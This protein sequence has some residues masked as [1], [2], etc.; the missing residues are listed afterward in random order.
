MEIALRTSTFRVVVLALGLAGLLVTG[1]IYSLFW[2]SIAAG[3]VFGAGGWLLDWRT[4]FRRLGG[5]L[6]SWALAAGGAVVGTKWYVDSGETA[7]PGLGPWPSGLQYASMVFLS[8]GILMF[9]LRD[10]S[11]KAK[12]RVPAP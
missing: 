7:L 9:A 6:S 1:V 3:L 5:Q 12:S 8:W 4:G 10:R 11:M 2:V